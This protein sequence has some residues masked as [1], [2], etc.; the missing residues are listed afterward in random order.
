MAAI[1]RLVTRPVAMW[2][3]IFGLFLV[4]RLIILVGGHIFTSNDAVTYAPRPGGSG[5]SMV[6]FAGNAPRPWGLPLFYAI[7][8][9]DQ[10]RVVGQWTI[11]TIAWAYFAWEL[12]RNLRTAWA[13]YAVAAG[14]LVLGLLRTIAN[15]DLAILSESLSISLGLLVLAFLLRW[16]RTGS[17]VAIV[18]MSA[19][20]IWWTFIR[21]DI[22]LFTLVLIATLLV[23]AGRAWWRRRRSDRAVAPG[24]ARHIGAALAACLAMGLGLVWY[25]AIAGPIERAGNA[26][27]LDGLQSSPLPEREQVLVYRLRVDVS[28]DPAMWSA[29]KSELAMPTCPE[30]EAFTTDPEWHARAWVE[31]YTRCPPLVAWVNQHDGSMFWTDLA[32]KDPGLFARTFLTKTS[33]ALGGTVYADVP[34][35]VPARAE[36]IVFPSRRY[37]LLLAL[38]GFGLSFAAAWMAGALKTHRRLV[39]FAATVFGTAILSAVA[40]IAE[41]TGEIARFGIQETVAT[42]IAM[43]VLL[44]CALDAWLLR[45]RRY[46]ADDASMPTSV[47]SQGQ[48]QQAA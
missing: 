27:D 10:W 32:T 1:W 18:A 28:T 37:G 31:A 20:A 26:Y 38:L 39:W 22:R 35:A 34:R 45:R 44:G 13:R 30:L 3:A 40:T 36:D 16:L 47:P 12:S 21:P 5:Q 46:G 33:L 7:L 8:G 48:A 42:R 23:I 29:F 19:C 2:T 43:V 41:Y 17:V 11:A 6:S 9:S 14:I 15:W 25:A 4:G 24:G